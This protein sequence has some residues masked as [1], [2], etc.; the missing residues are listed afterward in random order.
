MHEKMEIA[1]SSGPIVDVRDRGPY[2]S[3]N[4][5]KGALVNETAKIFDELL[6]NRDIENVRG[7]VLTGFLLPQKSRNTRRHIWTAINRRY[8]NLMPNWAL[9]HLEGAVQS[10]PKNRD[11]VSLVYL[12]F[13]LR[14]RLTYDF[15][16]GVVW[17][18]WRE[19]QLSIT[20]DDVLSFLDQAAGEEPQVRNWSN[21]SR[22]KLARNVLTA[23]RD[24][25]VL[26]GVQR[27]FVMKPELPLPTAEHLVRLLTA[28]GLKGAE[29][30]Q[31]SVWKLFL[32]TENEVAELLRTL[33]RPG[34]IRFERAGTAVLLDTPH[35]WT[36][37]A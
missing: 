33:S 7:Q 8:F 35:E 15:A 12:H 14:D 3:R 4:T 25:G 17:R 16:T 30:L 31:S 10:H 6:R 22:L 9:D 36:N 18:H 2:S 13:S 26:E 23:L 1:T 19:K 20:R 24:F 11:F 5:S 34:G 28:E 29:V 21:S 37:A 32:R 27:K